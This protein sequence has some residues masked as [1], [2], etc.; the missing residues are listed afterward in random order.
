[1]QN[2]PFGS[3][4]FGSSTLGSSIAAPA[5]TGFGST[6]GTTNS[7][8]GSTQKPA[9]GTSTSATP[10]TGSIFGFGQTNT[11][12]APTSGGIFGNTS[13][14]TTGTTSTFGQP[15]SNTQTPFGSTL[16]TSFGGGGTTGSTGLFGGSGASTTT[17]IFGQNQQQTGTSSIFGG[18]TAN[19]QQQ[20]SSTG[21][22]FG[23][24]SGLNTSAFGNTLG[25][26]QSSLTGNTGLGSFG[27]LSQNKPSIFG[28]ATPSSQTTQQPFSLNLGSTQLSTNNTFGSLG[29]NQNQQN[30]SLGFGLNQNTSNNSF[31]GSSQQQQQ[32]QQQLNS[33]QFNSADKTVQAQLLALSNSPYG[34]AFNIKKGLQDID[35]RD[36]IL[37]PVSPIAQ[38]PYIVEAMSPSK[39]NSGVGVGFLP[40]SD[41][42]GGLSQP[43]RL[44]PKALTTVSLNK[45]ADLFEG[46]EDEDA[47]CF[48]PRKNVK[49]LLIKPN[50]YDHSGRSSI[51]GSFNGETKL[52]KK[53]QYNQIDESVKYNENTNYYGAQ[54]TNDFSNLSEDGLAT[55]LDNQSETGSTTATPHPANIVLE[56]PGYFTIPSLQD[57]AECVDSKGDC[58][59]ENFA[60]G[61]IDYGCITFPGMTNL[62]NMNL[63]EIVQIRR[64]EVH[65]YP[66]DKNKPP[67][68]QGLN[69]TAEITLHRIWPV[70]KQ[71]KESIT[72]PDQ[73]IQM[74]YNKKIENATSK[75]GAQFIDYD[76]ATGK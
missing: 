52:E 2:K 73:I 51:N 15:A 14:T 34:N 49:K 44:T 72:D 48:Y 40:G 64:K 17:N 1:L 9:F 23:N 62:A 11:T 16:N 22:I 58:F 50:N 61:R 76:P 18:T 74:S 46:L 5:S 42:R 7:I 53:T 30:T 57:L 70:H 71:T 12:T 20:Q 13:G 10:A 33:Q 75:M 43:V 68:G 25:T 55:N 54:I 27:S 36:D 59:V 4:P 65:V 60:I 8:F 47:Q 66:D 19:T 67:V 35:K 37:K 38:R 56:R 24:N 39:R 29:T 6:T 31:L 69:K 45:K 3:S 21:S 26:T 63:D 41:L 28:S 32:Q